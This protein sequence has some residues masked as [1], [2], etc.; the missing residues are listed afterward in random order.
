MDAT[1]IP[2]CYLGSEEESSDDD[3][4]GSVFINLSRD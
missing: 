4:E 3:S 2:M 1:D